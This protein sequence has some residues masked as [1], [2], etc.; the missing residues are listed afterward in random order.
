M[1]MTKVLL[2]M[3]QHQY[4]DKLRGYG[5]EY[6]IFN[7]AFNNLGYKVF[8]FDSWD[9][10]ITNYRALNE[11]FVA[12][13]SAIRPDIIF[14][15]TLRCEIWT[16]TL[17][18]IRSFSDAILIN[19]TTDDSWKY[20][21]LSKFI[22]KYYDLITTTYPDC[23]RKY[24]KDGIGGV[25]LTQWAAC[26]NLLAAPKPSSSCFYGVTF[27]GAAHGNRKKRINFLRRNGIKVD[28]FGHGWENGSISAEQI[29]CI[30]NDSLISLNFSNS[31]GEKQLKA[32]VFEVCGAGGF[33]LTEDSP[34]LSRFYEVGFEIDVFSSDLEMLEKV[35][36]YLE[37]PHIRDSMAK[38]SYARTK[39]EHTYEKR[40]IKILQTSIPKP[41]FPS[42][43]DEEWL[44]SLDKHK[45]NFAMKVLKR[46]MLLPLEFFLG[47]DRGYRAARRVVYRISIFLFG[48]KAYS[49]AGWVGILFPGK[50]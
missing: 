44:K 33:L 37:N 10:G 50:G 31:I 6:L 40:L 21:L 36:F 35:N 17:K 34:H 30:M 47:E 24:E 3:G 43:N 7:K 48:E 25:I 19:W 32:R 27:I 41:I 15:V 20:A 49:S 18:Y 5:T 9:A 14:V 39:D 8:N 11:D 13:V 45:P 42:I 26:S 38:L 4:G 46:V 16:E 23:L 22:G 12:K 29:P 28:C 1:N 2:V